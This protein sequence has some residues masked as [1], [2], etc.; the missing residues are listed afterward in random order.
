[1]RGPMPRSASDRMLSRVRRARKATTTAAA[2]SAKK[3]SFSSQG[4]GVRQPAGLEA[5]GRARW[6]GRGG[7]DV[8]EQSQDVE[9]AG[10]NVAAL[11]R[12][13]DG[14]D[15]QGMDGEDERGEGGAPAEGDGGGGRGQGHLEQ[16][17]GEEV[18]GE[19]G[20]GVEEEAGEVVAGGVQAPEAIV[21]ADGEPGQGHVVARVEGGE[22]PAELS[23]A[24]A[25][26]VEIV[27]KIQGIVPGGEAVA[28]CRR[29]R[30]ERHD[31]NETRREPA[32]SHPDR[33]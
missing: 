23:G 31:R 24:E 32:K 28:E 19:R 16:A 30:G 7:L 20:G 1:M 5:R 22:H 18:E 15:T 4:R 3:G 27:E 17:E 33:S 2:L 25:P 14:F 12:P 29:K 11:G 21:E 26:V 8:T 6:R 10:E 9:E 13:G